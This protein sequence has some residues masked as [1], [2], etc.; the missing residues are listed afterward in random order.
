MF[1]PISARPTLS[2][3]A[4]LREKQ[5][6]KAAHEHDLHWFGAAVVKHYHGDDSDLD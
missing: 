1:G 4:S 5:P 2:R 3:D 6:W